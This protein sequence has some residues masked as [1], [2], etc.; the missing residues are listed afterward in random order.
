M[1]SVLLRDRVDRCD[2]L[3]CLESA[4]SRPGGG[5]LEVDRLRYKEAFGKRMRGM[6]K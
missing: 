6:V 4:W 3:D 5:M 1:T 2:D